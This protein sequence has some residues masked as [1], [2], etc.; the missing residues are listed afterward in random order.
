[1]INP[2]ELEGWLDWFG[3]Y[4]GYTDRGATLE[5][6]LKDLKDVYAQGYKVYMVNDRQTG[7]PDKLKIPLGTFETYNE[8]R[9]DEHYE[10][11]NCKIHITSDGGYSIHGKNELNNQSAHPN[12]ASNQNGRVCVGAAD[13]L[14]DF[15][16]ERD[17][18]MLVSSLDEFV[19]VYST[20]HPYWTPEIPV[21]ICDGCAMRGVGVCDLC[22]CHAQCYH[23]RNIA[24]FRVMCR[25]P[26]FR[27]LHAN[28]G[29]RDDSMRLFV[30]EL[31]KQN[32][33]QRILDLLFNDMEW[34]QRTPNFTTY[35]DHYVPANGRGDGAFLLELNTLEIYVGR[36]IKTIMESQ[37][38]SIPILTE[39]IQNGE[40]KYERED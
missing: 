39:G 17:L 4:Y 32:G 35:Y 2:N 27:S 31:I 13:H 6:M 7:R 5:R 29:I 38:Q 8:N 22:Y 11:Q 10:I 33:V 21:N 3:T 34:N 23:G 19:H 20:E 24:P 1:M 15:A 12:V 30:K 9:P 25:E 37:S 26:C 16:E 14:D 18:A 28:R 36:V 40:I